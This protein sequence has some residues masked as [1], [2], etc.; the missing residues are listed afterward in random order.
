MACRMLTR[1]L[2]GQLRGID[3]KIA[4]LK[5]ELTYSSTGDRDQYLAGI[6]SLQSEKAKLAQGS[7]GAH[8][9]SDS[10]R[11]DTGSTSVKD[12]ED[13]ATPPA[14]H[15]AGDCDSDSDEDTSAADADDAHDHAQDSGE[16]IGA[17][18]TVTQKELREHFHLPLHTVAK[19]LGMCTTAFKKLCRRFGIAKW[20]HRQLRGIDKKIA[21]LKAELNYSTVD[22]ESARRNLVALEEEKARLSRVALGGGGSPAC[23]GTPAHAKDSSQQAASRKRR[24]PKDEPEANKS[25]RTGSDSHTADA[26]ALDLLAAVAGIDSAAPSSH[27]APAAT[28]SSGAGDISNLISAPA[29]QLRMFPETAVLSRER[30]LVQRLQGGV[31][32]DVG[33]LSSRGAS[34]RSTPR[35][36][37][38]SPGVGPQLGQDAQRRDGPIVS[39]LL[40]SREA[41]SMGAIGPIVNKCEQLRQG[42]PASFH[43]LDAL[44][45]LLASGGGG[46][47]GTAGG[48]GTL[49]GVQS[50]QMTRNVVGIDGNMLLRLPQLLHR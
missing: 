49:M 26:S 22:K 25:A 27:A 29:Q 48:T 16:L 24:A 1:A 44:M 11:S 10:E 35:L 15:G 40:S 37:P 8:H 12:E 36:E 9:D 6:S 28:P 20:P 46:G 4:A 42:G 19:K 41:M 18:I 45:S 7:M 43:S 38:L 5:T 32:G 33:G 47:G 17:G 31:R 39:P 14:S 34:A 50:Q 3:K 23:R 21:A 30:E 2:G 13:A